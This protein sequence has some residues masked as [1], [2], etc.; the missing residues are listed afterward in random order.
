MNSST[1]KRSCAIFLLLSAINVSGETLSSIELKNTSPK[2]YTS[3]HTLSHDNYNEFGVS[4][5]IQTDFMLNDYNAF[6][7][8]LGKY[9]VDFMNRSWSLLIIGIGGKYK[10]W[11]AELNFGLFF[12]DDY[13]N[14]SLS[15]KFN[16]TKYGIDFGYNLVNTRRFIVTPKTS[17]NWN[18]Y[19]LINSSKEKVHLEDYVHYRDLDIRFNQLTGFVGLI[20]SYKF[21][22]GCS[23]YDYWTVGLYGGYIFQFNEKP[24]MYSPDKRLINHNKIY[25]KNYSFGLRFSFNVG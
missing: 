6:K 4:F 5:F 8:I 1:L 21:Y 12:A 16:K 19:R 17:V 18:R 22:E 24:W 20:V 11:L 7:T 2:L 23:P 9:N 25:L 10:K 15:I 14:D 13:K 3:K